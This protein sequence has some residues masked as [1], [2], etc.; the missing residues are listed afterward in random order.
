MLVKPLRVSWAILVIAG[1]ALSACETFRENPGVFCGG[2]CAIGALMMADRTVPSGISKGQQWMSLCPRAVNGDGQARS[3]VAWHY[4]HGWSPV[5]QDYVRAY[6]WYVL[7][8]QAA[9][10]EAASYRDDLTEIMTS[11]QIAEAE[12]LVAQWNP[13]GETCEAEEAKGTS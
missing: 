3:N 7:A 12:R 10:S 6:V 13:D 9:Y 1:F 5:K 2:L 11:D 4:R 8:Y